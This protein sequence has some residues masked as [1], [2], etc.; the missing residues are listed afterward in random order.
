M[1]QILLGGLLVVGCGEEKKEGGYVEKTPVPSAGQESPAAEA[2]EE[3]GQSG[4]GEG[5]TGDVADLPPLPEANDQGIH[6]GLVGQA[7]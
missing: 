3:A 5:A 7:P 6:H 1:F 2:P 4:A